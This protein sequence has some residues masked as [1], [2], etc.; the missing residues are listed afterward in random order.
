[1]GLVEP[2]RKAD[3]VLHAGDVC[4]PE[5]L[6]TLAQFAPV[7]VALGNNDGTAVAGFALP[8]PRPC[9]ARAAPSMSGD[10]A[11]FWGCATRN[12]RVT[13]ELDEVGV[14]SI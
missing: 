13:P 10:T 12:R 4:T 2:L 11:E 6:E 8:V 5:V 1:M 9:R 3:L 7:T 14:A